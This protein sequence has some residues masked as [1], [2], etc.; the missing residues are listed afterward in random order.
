ME[1]ND[2]DKIKATQEQNNIVGIYIN[3]ENLEKQKGEERKRAYKIEREKIENIEKELLA[4]ILIATQE[5]ADKIAAQ[6][7]LEQEESLKRVEEELRREEELRLQE[8]KEKQ[9]KEIIDNLEKEIMQKLL[10]GKK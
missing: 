10:L 7:K 1:D 9:E 2:L 8:E 3:A 4:R 5:E 6:K